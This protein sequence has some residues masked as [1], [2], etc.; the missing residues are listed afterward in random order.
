MLRYDVDL[1]CWWNKDIVNKVRKLIRNNYLSRLST[2]GIHFIENSN[3]LI[4]I[5]INKYIIKIFN[6]LITKIIKQIFF[7]KLIIYNKINNK[8][9]RK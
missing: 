7:K 5:Y 9:A 8:I 3:N 2:S 1:I 6:I 4:I